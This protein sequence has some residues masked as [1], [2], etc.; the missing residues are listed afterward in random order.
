MTDDVDFVQDRGPTLT[1][2]AVAVLDAATT[3]TRPVVHHAPALSSRA[4]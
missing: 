3:R 4:T 1:D 2:H